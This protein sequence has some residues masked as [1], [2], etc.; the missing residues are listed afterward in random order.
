MLDYSVYRIFNRR[1]YIIVKVKLS[2]PHQL[3]SSERDS[4]SQLF[5]EAIQ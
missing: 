5:L 4:L 2:V 1:T 3:T